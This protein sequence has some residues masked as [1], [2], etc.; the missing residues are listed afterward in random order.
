[1]NALGP[2]PSRETH[3]VEREFEGGASNPAVSANKSFLAEPAVC[4]VPRFSNS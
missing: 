4:S 1:M 2:R 3:V